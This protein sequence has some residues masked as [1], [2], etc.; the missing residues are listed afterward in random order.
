MINQVRAPQAKFVGD[1]SPAE[2]APTSDGLG[3][4]I[5][6]SVAVHIALVAI[7]IVRMVIYPSETLRLEDAIRV[8]I[9]ALPDK[10]PKLP[11]SVPVVE[12]KIPPPSPPP[13]EPLPDVKLPEPAAPE[14]LVKPAPAPPKPISPKINLKSTKKA[15]DA[16]LKRL[17]ALE[18]IER[19][20][21]S[22]SRPAPSA[23]APIKGNQISHGASL[24]GVI[25]LEQQG[26]LQTIDGAVKSHWNLPGF[27]STANLT[28]RARLF[29]DAKGV[30][31]KRT[32]TQ[33]SHNDIYDQRVLS[34]IDTSS[35]LPPPPASLVN[36][37]ETDGIELEFVPQ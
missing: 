15:Q 28:A 22:Q 17:E 5:G 16:A 31:T 20:T 24:S 33:S 19:M 10:S 27:L 4:A 26:Y 32:L 21:K 14:P 6:L 29:I 2:G 23:P 13:P 7:F 35:P 34:A 1:G 18:K 9:V 3:R 25:R 37:L 8:D 12:T 36:I 11:M 30:V